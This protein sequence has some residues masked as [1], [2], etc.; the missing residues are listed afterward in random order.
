VNANQADF[1]VQAMC[2]VLGLSPSGYYAWLNRPPSKRAERDAELVVKIR[3]VFDDNR[4]VYGRP[5]IFADLKEQGESVGEKRVGRLMKQE[6]IQGASRRKR[7]PK[8]TK[9]DKDARPAPDLVE[10]DFAAD[11]PDQLWVADITYIPTW[12][13]F[14]Y[15]A[16]VLDAWS[17]RIVGWAMA[18]HLRT[19]LVLEALNMATWQRRPKQ[20][21]HHSDQGCQYTSIAFGLRCR[22]VDVRPSMGSVGDAYDNAMCESFFATLECELLDRKRFKTQAEAR[23]AVFDFIEGFYNPRR[24]H[25]ALGQISPLNFERR[26]A[27]RVEADAA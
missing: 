8:T 2:R 5:R 10:R 23:M 11:G 24:R 17:R 19:E 4:Q 27:R 16:V 21:I 3:T 13:G 9:R 14:L 20:V 12:A 7:G 25:S 22:E 18:T 1:P 26:H 15:L 6:E